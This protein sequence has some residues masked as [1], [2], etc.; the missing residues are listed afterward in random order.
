MEQHYE[1]PE[2]VLVGQADDVVQGVP[3]L[4]F[5]GDMGWVIASVEY[6]QD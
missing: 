5:D 1:I 2:L 4:G 6:E 3:G